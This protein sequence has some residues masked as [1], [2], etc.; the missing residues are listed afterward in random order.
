MYETFFGLKRRPFLAVPDTESYFSTELMEESLRS[1]ERTVR[2][3]EGIAL[4]F[5]DA[6]TG[7]TLLLR[8][9]RDSLEADFTVSMISNGHLETVKSFFQQILYDLQLP[10]SGND[11]TEL[12]FRLLDFARQNRTCVILIDESQFLSTSVLEEIRLLMNCDNGAT[13]LFRIVLAGTIEFEEKL[14]D[15]CLDA[16]NQRVVCRAYLDTFSREETRQYITQ[17]TD[18][19]QKQNDQF[20]E[21]GFGL[22]EWIKSSGGNEGRRIDSP[23]IRY[24]EPIFTENAQWQIFQ[25]TD[26][27][28]RSINQL[29]DMALQI[30]AE[31]KLR[32]IDENLVH[33]A[34]MRLQQITGYSEEQLT[35]SIAETIKTSS[36]EN[37]DEIVAR[38]KATFQLKTF[39]SPVE[40]GTLDDT[41]FVDV[42]EKSVTEKDVTKMKTAEITITEKEMIEKEIMEK[43]TAE[44][45]EVT[46]I[47]FRSPNEYKPPYPEDDHWEEEYSESIISESYSSQSEQSE[48]PETSESDLTESDFLEADLSESEIIEAINESLPELLPIVP[49]TNNVQECCCSEELPEIEENSFDFYEELENEILF[50]SDHFPRLRELP[51]SEALD[52]AIKAVAEAVVEKNVTENATENVTENAVESTIESVTENIEI[53]QTI[54]EEDAEKNVA[55]TVEAFQ[56][57]ETTEDCAENIVAENSEIFQT[58]TKIEIEKNIIDCPPKRIYPFRRQRVKEKTIRKYRRRIIISTI[59]KHNIETPEQSCCRFLVVSIFLTLRRFDSGNTWIGNLWFYPSFIFGRFLVSL[60]CEPVADKSV[61]DEHVSDERLINEQFL[62]EQFISEQFSDEQLT[63]EQFTDELIVDET[64]IDNTITE[65]TIIESVITESVITESAIT[66]NTDVIETIADEIVA[67][68]T[69]VVETATIETVVVETETPE[70]NDIVSEETVTSEFVVATEINDTVNNEPITDEIIVEL[71][72]KNCSEESEMDRETLEKYGAEILEGRPPFIRR[73]PNYAYQ[74]TDSAPEMI[75]KVAYPDL[76]TGNVILLNWIKSEQ[77]PENGFGTPYREFLTREAD[78][79]C[80]DHD[81]HTNEQEQLYSYNEFD[82]LRVVRIT[83][84]QVTDS[85][86]PVFVPQNQKTSLDELFDEV[87]KVET[88]AVPSKESFDRFTSSHSIYLNNF[89]FPSQIEEVVRRITKAAETIELAAEQSND[90]GRQIKQAAGIVEAEIKTVLPTYVEHF[91]ELVEFQQ[92][93]SRELNA[94]LIKNQIT[95]EQAEH[96]NANERSARLLPFPVRVNSGLVNSV[97]FV[98][99]IN[100]TSPANVSSSNPNEKS[101]NFHSLFQ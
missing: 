55:E 70:Y 74:T 6:G 92:T 80:N 58:A 101:I 44:N 30:A 83:L 66:E 56:I 18:L 79:N 35:E 27:L 75:G 64:V 24:H 68:E 85:I 19:S 43:E 61:I 57:T 98:S 84:N 12:R 81:H 73:E 100:E 33:R 36:F 48:Q 89:S 42:T 3:G 37:I 16:F 46:I 52:D 2:R 69:D 39:D 90:A 23:H 86:Q 8:L 62:D 25:L 76:V 17:Q 32:Q 7:K 20:S 51:I 95:K 91:R 38:K 11:E 59:S 71:N 14:T 41:E 26:G 96:L 21:S 34:R 50:S 45:D 87:I 15:P 31:R 60:R 13:P 10:F 29:C 9:L 47:R 65:N 5:G 63:D 97:Q 88:Q 82:A 1:I 54:T 94:T 22:V 49:K 28:P 78:H 4:L 53:F 40:F 77:N 99:E 67:V 93:I 72:R